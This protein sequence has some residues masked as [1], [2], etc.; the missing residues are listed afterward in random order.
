MTWPMRSNP[1]FGPAGLSER[2]VA[3]LSYAEKLTLNPADVAESDIENLRTVGLSD[4]DI[5]DL[6]EV[7]GYFA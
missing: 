5:L 3:M 6:V 2:R 1:T 7:V 4:R